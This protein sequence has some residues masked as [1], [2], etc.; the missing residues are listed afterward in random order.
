MR[1]AF[2]D[3][4]LE[5]HVPESLQRALEANGHTVYNTGKIGHGFTFETRSSSLDNI[6]RHID[7]V[8]AFDPDFVLVFRP[9]SLP[10][11][12]LKRLKRGAGRIGVWLSDDPVLW[13]LSYRPV[14]ELY[15]LVFNCGTERVLSFYDEH[16]GR[17]VGVN[18][19]FWT[20]SV[21]FPYVYG[22]HVPETTAMF[23]GNVQDEVR[24]RRYFELSALKTDVRIHGN[25]GIDFHNMSAGYLDS[26]AEVAH[27][28]SLVRIA[29]N[30]PQFFID[31]VGLDTWFDGL[32]ELGTFQ[33]PS[34]V[35]QYAAMG[36]P[37]VSVT[38]EPDAYDTFPELRLVDSY[39][40]IDREVSKLME[41]EAYLWE[42]SRATHTR[43]Q[44]HFSAESRAM[45]LEHIIS[46]DSWH[47][48]SLKERARWFTQ[49]DGTTAQPQDGSNVPTVV[50]AGERNMVITS[51]SCWEDPGAEPEGPTES[52]RHNHVSRNHS[53]RTDSRPLR[54][55][56][57]GDGWT[58]AC[59]FVN[60]AKRALRRL[61]HDPV[62]VSPIENPAVFMRD[63]SGEFNS[64]V[65]ATKLVSS[66]DP[67][68]VILSGAT[69]VIAQRGCSYLES[70]GVPIV[71][72]GIVSRNPN[73]VNSKLATRSHYFTV[74][75]PELK[76]TLN[77]AGFDNLRLVP[78]LVD[79]EFLELANSGACRSRIRAIGLRRA[80]LASAPGVVDDLTRLAV[81]F[82]FEDEQPT[83]PSDVDEL[84]EYVSSAVTVV[85]HDTSLPGIQ[86]SE[87]FGFALAAGGLVATL[88]APGAAVGG[89]AGDT[90]ITVRDRHELL[91]KLSR[92]RDDEAEYSRYLRNSARY[93]SQEC[94][95]EK[96][97]SDIIDSA[98]SEMRFKD[99]NRSR[100]LW[101]D[102]AFPGPGVLAHQTWKPNIAGLL[103]ARLTLTF[104]YSPPKY[105]PLLRQVRVRI[106]LGPKLVAEADLVDLIGESRLSVDVPSRIA[107]SSISCELV[108]E[109]PLP[110]FNWQSYVALDVEFKQESLL[111][112]VVSLQVAGTNTSF[113]SDNG[114]R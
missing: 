56:L 34:R 70:R 92:L 62:Q 24:R 63:S 26:D 18:M 2:F 9:A 68:V 77:A 96:F 109:S 4:L 28:A 104:R 95:A 49:F 11:K 101:L 107:R 64:F 10:P 39:S 75:H 51:S 102:S 72:H 57:I 111:V 110:F 66:V 6:E 61:G 99:A 73:I 84:L 87:Y 37:I 78:P 112:P 13:D 40:G 79:Q 47:S 30:I 1:I 16:F 105:H 32:A 88:R 33:Y 54:V 42:L 46:D 94:S 76:R 82:S 83:A 50:G 48:L 69:Y 17:P 71:V 81:N 23:L 93:I 55:A 90:H 36:L 52:D 85:A 59:S 80:D 29:I 91:R 44:R 113:K 108:S 41:D 7:R 89:I 74:N 98:F 45:A 20:D 12:Q 22:K 35:I 31:H 53:F 43:F 86:N 14:V 21:A 60:I 38:P 58:R 65:D 27:A 5:R 103:S 8:I 97:L 3:G 114:E 19:P 15:D 25:T 100:T 106:K 67:D